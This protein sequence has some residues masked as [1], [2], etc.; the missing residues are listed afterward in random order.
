MDQQHITEGQPSIRRSWAFSFAVLVLVASF[1]LGVFVG[2]QIMTVKG[3]FDVRVANTYEAGWN[4]ARQRL[5][6]SDIGRVVNAQDPRSIR[7][8]IESVGSDRVGIRVRAADPLADPSLDKRVVLVRNTTKVLRLDRKESSVF[9]REV[10]IFFANLKSKKPS[11]SLRAP[12]PFIGT[13]IDT[14]NLE[15]GDEVFVVASEDIKL[16][17]EFIASEIQ[18]EGRKVVSAASVPSIR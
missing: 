1:G 18:S 3:P 15:V 9:Q 5:A 7:G 13:A 8:T 4:A 6:E 11:D 16:A 17:K 14:Q 12:E 10:D 2:P